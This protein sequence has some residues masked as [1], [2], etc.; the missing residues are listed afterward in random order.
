MSKEKIHADYAVLNDYYAFYNCAKDRTGY[1]GVATFCKK[2][3]AT[4]F[5]VR[6]G[7]VIEDYRD[8]DFEG[9]CLV[10]DHSDFILFNVYFPFSGGPDRLTYKIWFM[11]VI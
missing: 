9:R 3:I 8:M 4:P 6:M 7:F 1:S 2:E 10:T 11:R 5:N